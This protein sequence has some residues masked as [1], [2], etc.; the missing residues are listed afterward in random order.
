MRQAGTG[1]LSSALRE[2]RIP[3][4]VELLAEMEKK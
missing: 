2:V 1:L 4:K 3:S